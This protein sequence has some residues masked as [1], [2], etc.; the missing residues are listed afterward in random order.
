VSLDTSQHDAFEKDAFHIVNGR[1]AHEEE[2][3]GWLPLPHRSA[4]DGKRGDLCQSMDPYLRVK[5][6]CVK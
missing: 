1:R 3:E 4:P 5:T 6:A 2:Q